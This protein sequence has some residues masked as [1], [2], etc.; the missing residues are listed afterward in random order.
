MS[1]R[2]V[3]E[4]LERWTREGS[5]AAVATL[6]A[7]KRSA[8]RPPGARFAV[9][10]SGELAGSVSSGCVEGDLHEHLLGIL[11]GAP[12]AILHYGITDELAAEVGLACGGEIDVLVALHE[13]D[14]PVWPA[15][16]DALDRVRPAVLLTGLSEEVR[17]RRLL[18]TEDGVVVGSLGSPGLDEAARR[19]ARG[20]FDAEGTTILEWPLEDP[21]RR[22]S[23]PADE[24]VPL[25]RAFAEVYLPPPRLAIIGATPVAA[26]LCHIAAYAGVSVTI[27]DPRPALADP[28][29][30]PAADRVLHA[31]PEEGLSELGADR[32]LGVVALAHDRKLDVPAL[33]AALRAG[34][35]YVGQ[36]GGRRT[37]RLRR[38]A[39][40]ELG[41]DDAELTR[42]HGPV[43][44]DI[45]A[46]TPEEIALAVLAEWIAVRRG[47]KPRR[48]SSPPGPVASGE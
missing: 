22:S 32:Y 26:A 15:L 3:R 25:V 35:L 1:L 47:R 21:G 16:G 6:V 13:P 33:A 10:E 45:G 23:R 9:N 31:W 18:L 44:L 48:T 41:F 8:P 2:E 36:I 43:G 46:E 39:L 5:R 14:D 27:I 38:E 7:V 29:K 11:A 24:A 19:M 20:L 28:E 30:F 40:A 12:P 4:P 34:C 37:Q 17:A 42:I